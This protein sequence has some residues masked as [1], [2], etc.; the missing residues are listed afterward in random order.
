MYKRTCGC[1][2]DL[3]NLELLRYAH[4]HGCP[5]DETTCESAAEFNYLECF[6]YALQNGCEFDAET[7]AEISE[8]NCLWY[9]Y[10]NG[11]PEMDRY[12]DNR[13]A[14]LRELHDARRDFVLDLALA[15]KADGGVITASAFRRRL[16]EYR[17][18]Y[19]AV[20]ER[21]FNN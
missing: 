13:E 5:W 21:F 18:K 6:R 9:A 2:A 10:V 14:V 12:D 17:K 20:R 3:G 19:D 7:L 15:Y 4:E 16:G 1:A 11:G 8:P